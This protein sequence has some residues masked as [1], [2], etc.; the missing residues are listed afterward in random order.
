[1]YCYVVM[2]DHV[3]VLVQP[4]SGF[5][6]SAIVSSWKSFTSTRMRKEFNRGTS[7]WQKDYFDRIVRDEDELLEK[8]NYM[9]SNPLKRWPELR[10]Y[11]WMAWIGAG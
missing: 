11:R 3:Y 7:V 8:A 9:L 1:M 5:Q 2:D 6:L 4:L 10:D